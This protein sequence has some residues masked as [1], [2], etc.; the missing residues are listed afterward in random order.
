MVETKGAYNMKFLHLNNNTRG[1]TL[2]EMMVIAPVVILLIGTIIFSIVQITG[3]ALA[4]RASS[5]LI[6]N[7]Q[8]ALDQIEADTKLSGAFLAKN[9]VTLTS[10]QGF[11]NGTVDF[12]SISGNGAMLILNTFVTTQNPNSANRSLVYLANSPYAC[13]HANLPQNQVM[14]MNTVYFVQDNTLWKRTL[15]PTGYLNRD[16]PGVTPWQRPSC[17]PGITGT[18][19]PTQDERLVNGVTSANFTVEYFNSPSDNTA[20]A[21][22]QNSNESTRQS[23]LDLTNTVQVTIK[24]TIS[25]SG[26]DVSQQGTV[27]ATRV[28]SLIKYATP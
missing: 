27:R 1:F 9:N 4:E 25:A 11:G 7:V 19:C 15:A 16:C 8:S 3:E 10:P 14:T 23:A 12:Q 24:S 26:R 21:D 17:A 5:V 18:L 13:T 2:V 22:A 20:S 28:G 6:S